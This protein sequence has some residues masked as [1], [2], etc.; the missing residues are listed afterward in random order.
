MILSLNFAYKISKKVIGNWKL[1]DN[2]QLRLLTYHSEF[3]HLK[4]EKKKKNKNKLALLEN[5][6]KCHQKDFIYTYTWT[7]KLKTTVTEGL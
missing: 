3:F 2:F 6:K 4:L 1:E 7:R 5:D